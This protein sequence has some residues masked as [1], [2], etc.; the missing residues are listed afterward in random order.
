MMILSQ[1]IIEYRLVI[2]GKPIGQPRAKATTV[3]GFARLYSP[4]HAV[5]EFKAAI[6]QEAGPLF[7]EPLTGAVC[8]SLVC[9]FPRPKSK[10]WKNKPMPAEPHISKPDVDNVIKAGLDALKSIAWRDDC[11]VSELRVKKWVAAGDEQ[12]RTEIVIWQSV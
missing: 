4:R 6:R 2:Y 3:G 8:V 5:D 1:P 9:V 12:P 11:Q 10:L 7:R